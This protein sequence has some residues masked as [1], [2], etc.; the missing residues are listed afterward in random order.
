MMMIHTT[1]AAAVSPLQQQQKVPAHGIDPSKI[2]LPCVNCRAL[3][4]VPHGMTRFSCPQC[5]T[6]LVVDF[7]KLNHL[8]QD[9]INEVSLS[10]TFFPL[11]FPHHFQIH[12]V[13][14]L[15]WLMTL[16]LDIR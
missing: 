8:I 7:S 6:T 16:G 15:S 9:E 12:Y 10:H 11:F 2:Q 14:F 3:L 13:L 5:R 1:A 4:N